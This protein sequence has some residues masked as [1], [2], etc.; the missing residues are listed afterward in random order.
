[1]FYPLVYTYIKPPI[2]AFVN[3]FRIIFLLFSDL[4]FDNVF[5]YVVFDFLRSLVGHGD[6]DGRAG[7]D[8]PVEVSPYVT[9]VG[10]DVAAAAVDGNVCATLVTLL[11]DGGAGDYAQ[12]NDKGE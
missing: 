1:M 4:I 9:V 5:D 11:L 12:H 3:R 7:R 6:E 10:D 2:G 8:R